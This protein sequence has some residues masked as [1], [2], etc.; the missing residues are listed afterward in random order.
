VLADV[1][2]EPAWVFGT[3]GGAVTGLA[4]VSRHPERGVPSSPTSRRSQSCWPTARRSAP[5]STTSTAAKVKARHG[6]SSSPMPASSNQPTTPQRNPSSTN[7]RARSGRSAPLRRPGVVAS[8]E[9][10]RLCTAG[11]LSAA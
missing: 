7:L 8:Q 1:T 4:L 11:N 2:T 10:C 5:R 6:R 9:R 3:S